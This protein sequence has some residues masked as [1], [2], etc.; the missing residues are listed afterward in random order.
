MHLK[1]H[2]V[3]ELGW[4]AKLS[5]LEASLY[6]PTGKGAGPS[7][8]EA[9]AYWTR[10]NS[11]LLHSAYHFFFS[12]SDNQCM[13]WL[14]FSPATLLKPLETTCTKFSWNN[15]MMIL[16]QALQRENARNWFP[17]ANLIYSP[18]HA[19]YNSVFNWPVSGVCGGWIQTVDLL[20]DWC[21]TKSWRSSLAVSD[22][23]W[24][25]QKG[26]WIFRQT[27]LKI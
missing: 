25:A 26:I 7:E 16:S 20:A 23:F 15:L 21:P 22:R 6:E 2:F 5:L 17:S 19:H 18:M 8:D 4:T 27:L 11:K 3:P 12:S 1:A 10:L 13:C 24:R 9:A 14:I